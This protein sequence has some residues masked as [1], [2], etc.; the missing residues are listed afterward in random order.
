MKKVP[1]TILIIALIVTLAFIWGN[2]LLSRDMSSNESGFVMRLVT[3]FLEIFVGKG[4]VTEHLVRKL[5]HF[6]EYTVLGVELGFLFGV[7]RRKINTNIWRSW[8]MIFM[9]GMAIA[10]I[11]ETIQ[12]F[13][14]RGPAISDVWIDSLGATLGSGIVL[15]VLFL[16][17]GRKKNG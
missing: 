10:F 1:K 13:T 4:N 12:I 16:V 14:G 15:L 8:P 6:S 5:A 7:L 11:D 9:H 3:P 17:S 2:S